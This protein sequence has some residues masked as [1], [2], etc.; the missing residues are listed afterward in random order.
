MKPLSCPFCGAEPVLVS[1][2]YLLDHKSSCFLKDVE[3]QLDHESLVKWNTR[4]VGG[5]MVYPT[6]E[7]ETTPDQELHALARALSIKETIP[8]TFGVSGNKLIVYPSGEDIDIIQLTQFLVETLK[9]EEDDLEFRDV[10]QDELQEGE[11]SDTH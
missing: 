4:F 10:Y 2:T 1:Q 7:V 3:I 9:F 5:V 6:N 8:A 11:L